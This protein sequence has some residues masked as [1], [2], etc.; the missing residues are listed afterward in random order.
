MNLKSFVHRSWFIAVAAFAIASSSA[1]AQYFPAFPGFVNNSGIRGLEGLTALQAP[2]G[3]YGQVVLMPHVENGI[4]QLSFSTDG[5]NYQGDFR[6]VGPAPGYGGINY[7]VNCEA[8]RPDICSLGSVAAYGKIFIAFS[9]VSDK[10]LTIVRLDPVNGQSFYIGTTVYHNNAV[11]LTAAPAMALSPNNTLIVRYGTSNGSQKNVAYVTQ[12]NDGTS[13]STHVTN[14]LAPT[15]SG[16]VVFGGQFYFFD[17]QDNSDAGVWEGLLDNNGNEIANTSHQISGWYT[18]TGLSATVFNNN[19]VVAFQ[20]NSSQH[21]FT[22]FSSP[23][24]S[25]WYSQQYPNLENYTPKLANFNGGLSAVTIANDS[26]YSL[27]TD[28]TTH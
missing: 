11:Q 27:W 8:D 26:S 16:L 23:N 17:G 12:S 20:Q 10:G 13:F 22:I 28:Y 7:G 18:K 24:G 15:Q 6:P 21:H 1:Y 5:K 3:Y 9:D 25:S 19:I 4:V 14:G 2:N